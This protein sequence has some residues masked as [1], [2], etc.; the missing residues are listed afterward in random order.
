MI[1]S[2]NPRFRS[3]FALEACGPVN[4]YLYINHIPGGG[5]GARLTVLGPLVGFAYGLAYRNMV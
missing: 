4:R 3:R 1:F 2:E 5:A